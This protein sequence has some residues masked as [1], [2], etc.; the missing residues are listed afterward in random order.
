[1][2]PH[3]LC[4]LC[5]RVPAVKQTKYGRRR[6]CCGLWAWGDHPLVDAQTHAARKRAH[7]VFD[8]LWKSRRTRRAHA[9]QLL[10]AD[11]GLKVADCHMKLMDAETA[12]RVPAAVERI[13]QH[14]DI[15]DEKRRQNRK[16]RAT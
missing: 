11:L 12:S 13:K 7:D 10:A 15:R 6:S 1:M 8:P 9:Y 4:P 3:L 5:G 16:R 2:K 14:L